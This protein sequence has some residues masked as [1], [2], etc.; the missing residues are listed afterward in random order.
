MYTE[1]PIAPLLRHMFLRSPSQVII[2]STS[3]AKG[4][5]FWSFG[6]NTIHALIYLSN[7][8]Y[9]RRRPGTVCIRGNRLSKQLRM[10]PP[11]RSGA[12]KHMSPKLVVLWG[13]ITSNKRPRN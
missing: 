2:I 1:A 6:I 5:G 7:T 11:D 4:E 3:I 12:S 9:I 10:C 8:C 13:R